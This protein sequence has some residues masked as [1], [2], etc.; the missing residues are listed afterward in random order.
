MSTQY[1]IKDLERLSGIK[2][3]TLRI[4]EQRYGILKPERTDTNIRYYTTDD[5]KRI[6][7]ISLLNNNGFKISRIAE[8]PDYEM[9]K[10]AQSILNNFNKE[11][12]QIDNLVLCMMEM[13]ESKFEKIISNSII[14]F[15]FENTI[16]KIIFPFMHQIGS[17]WQVGIVS[18][19]Q[20]HFISHLVRQKLIVG[21]D[22]LC[23]ETVTQPKTFLLYLPA[24][25]MHELGLLYCQFLVKSKGHK[26]IYL[27]QSV[28]FSDLIS[29]A[30]I[31]QPDFIVTAFTHR[32]N[33]IDIHEYLLN[34]QKGFSKSQIL[35]SG[36][37][38]LDSN[39]PIAVP[40]S[41]NLFK[42]HQ[43]FKNILQEC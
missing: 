28:P 27:G 35:I 38:L 36:R 12:E 20:E 32:L 13:N 33:G 14:H 2:A 39:E 31:V 3:H 6:L 26:C 29:L 19:V 25:E 8:M 23:S 7:N 10:Q 40:K 24:N 41:V 21:I 11:S 9:L 17:M 15:G 37:L 43:Q 34:L 42:S 4:W 1:A 18:I 22:D 30:E 5:L 16:E